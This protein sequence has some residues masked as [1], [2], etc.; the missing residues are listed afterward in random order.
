MCAFFFYTSF[1]DSQSRSP[2]ALL[3][4]LPYSKVELTFPLP[5]HSICKQ[6]QSIINFKG[7]QYFVAWSLSHDRLLVTPWTV[8][9]QAPLF[10]EFSRQEYWS[11]LPFPS[12]GDLPDPGIEPRFLA[13]QVCSLPSEL[14]GKPTLFN[15]PPNVI[16]K[17]WHD[18]FLFF[19]VFILFLLNKLLQIY[20]EIRFY[21]ISLL[22][23]WK[24]TQ[25]SHS[26]GGFFTS[27]ATR[28]AQQYWSE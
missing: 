4:P 10:T 17:L 3:I 23:I 19:I 2:R 25:V 11:G 1:L 7:H 6:T 15:V 14:P 22:H 20:L 21:N 18:A 12:P 27:W 26:T 24:G 13:L 9:H 8:A 16:F 5:M 28:K